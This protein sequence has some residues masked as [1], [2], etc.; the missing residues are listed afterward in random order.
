MLS[1]LI[2]WAIAIA[3]ARFIRWKQQQHSTTTTTTT[4]GF[5][6]KR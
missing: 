1:D 5:K 4:T 2:Y 6:I 3:H